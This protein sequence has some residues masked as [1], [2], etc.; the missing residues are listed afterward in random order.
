MRYLMGERTAAFVRKEME[1][2]NGPKSVSAGASRRTA[3]NG[4]EEDAFAHP[5]EL[6]WAASAGEESGGQPKGAWIVW[7]PKGSLVLD[8]VE[9]STDDLTAANGYPD[10]WYDLTDIFG[11]AEAPEEFDLYLD[12]GA[13]VKFTV[14]RDSATN[15]V[16]IAQVKGKVV[17]GVVESALVAFGG[18]PFPWELRR[19]YDE[20]EEGTGGER[21][22][23]WRVWIPSAAIT[24][25]SGSVAKRVVYDS[26]MTPGPDPSVSYQIEGGSS[27]AMWGCA[28]YG[29]ETDG[30]RTAAA[31]SSGL[32][33]VWASV[34][35]PDGGGSVYLR[36]FS[37]A[38]DANSATV[39][40]TDV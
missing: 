11:E 29:G 17:K 12:V 32:S 10:G 26:G 30:E 4:F 15:P 36:V 5:F 38:G 23:V 35:V 20:P 16:L 27:S 6:R 1:R 40:L 19:F 34:S 3:S 7:L 22:P 9:A 24:L 18:A 28:N 8:G 14:E 25:I 39:E 2:A 21:V 37:A 31:V 33:G 13:K